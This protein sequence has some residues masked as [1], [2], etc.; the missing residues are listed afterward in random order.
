MLWGN[1]TAS[2]GTH[3]RACLDPRLGEDAKALARDGTLSYDHF[4]RQ[5]QAGQLLHLCAGMG[6]VGVVRRTRSC[7]HREGPTLLIQ[8]AFSLLSAQAA[9]SQRIFPV[10]RYTQRFSLILQP[11]TLCAF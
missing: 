11:K 1:D 2:E 5:H 4:H 6:V 9:P 3:L 10:A 7:M 8:D